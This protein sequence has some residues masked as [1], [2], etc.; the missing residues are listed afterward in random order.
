QSKAIFGEG[1]K[2][3]VLEVKTT[4]KPPKVQV[5]PPSE[6]ECEG[7]TDEKKTKTLVCLAS[8]FYPDHVTVSWQIN[9]FDEK[10]GVKTDD[11][12]TMKDDG[13]YT[14][15]SRLRV[16]ASKWLKKGTN[17]TCIVSFFDGNN[18]VPYPNWA[19]EASKNVENKINL[20]CSGTKHIF[21]SPEKYL[22]TMQSAKLSYTALVMKSSI[23]G[24]FVLLLVWKIQVKYNS[25]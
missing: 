10:Q 19:I 9:G 11:A 16:T 17:I 14:I 22:R 21:I 25:S 15:M 6:K 13:N 12:A 4:P 2:L 8:G 7:K 24:L 3:T 5:F 1:T 23:Y 18:T 20:Q